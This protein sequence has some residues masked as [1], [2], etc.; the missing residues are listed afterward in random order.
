MICFSSQRTSGLTLSAVFLTAVCLAGSDQKPVA[1]DGAAFL[2]IDGVKFSS[3]D[4]QKRSASALYQAQNALFE[5]EKKASDD[6]IDNYLLEREA[7][8]QG[9]TVAELLKRNV[10]QVIPKDPSEDALQVFYEGLNIAAPY[11][12]VRSQIIDSIRQRRTTKAKRE[13]LQ[14]LRAKSSIVVRLTPP[15]LQLAL[16]SA[17]QR[18]AADAQV[19]LVEYAD[20]ECPYCQQIQ[21]AVERLEAEY[22]GR[23]SFIYRDVPLP[24]HANAQKAAEATHCARQQGKYWE[25]HDVLLT[26]KQLGVEQ[27]KEHARTLKLDSDAFSKCLDSGA[28]APVVKASLDEAQSFGLPGTPGFVVNGRFLNGAVDYEKLK[29]IIEE[30]LGATSAAGSAKTLSISQR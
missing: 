25:Y 6:F 8:K 28:M 13:Y 7:K 1:P 17:P 21:P 19:R 20:Y 9:I 23:I 14:S 4:V 12:S 10:D 30:E 15:R 2:E 16:D 27:L 3:A 22:K 11:Q 26:S 29:Q 24:M 5:A 18:G